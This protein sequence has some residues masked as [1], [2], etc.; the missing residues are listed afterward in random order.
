MK[1][2]LWVLCALLGV[3]TCKNV[4]GAP[5]LDDAAF[6]A[7][8]LELRGLPDEPRSTFD[9][10]DKREAKNV[11]NIVAIE[12][13]QLDLSKREAKN[14]VDLHMT[15]DEAKL[16]TRDGKN[17]VDLRLSPVFDEKRK[18]EG[19]NVVNLDLTLDDGLFKRSGCGMHMKM[20]DAEISDD[21]LEQIDNVNV[22]LGEKLYQVDTK[23]VDGDN[24]ALKLI[25]WTD[26]VASFMWNLTPLE[27]YLA[28][29]EAYLSSQTL[30][31][32]TKVSEPL[33]GDLASALTINEHLSLYSSYVR[34][35]SDVYT[36]CQGNY[37]DV[38]TQSEQPSQHLLFAPTNEALYSLKSKP[39]QFPTSVEG[40]SG[41]EADAVIESNVRSFVEAHTVEAEGALLGESGLVE[42]TT[43][44]GRTV[45]LKNDAGKG[46]WVRSSQTDWVLVQSVQVVENG[47][48]L[49]IPGAL[50]LP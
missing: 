16:M 41:S 23:E 14:V 19:K 26:S 39:W 22:R 29:A 40:L 9:L 27:S 11:V 32:S 1:L 10:L 4:V 28:K 7:L 5:I 17:V 2:A 37:E 25:P 42:L 35:L 43:L 31:G 30:T 8:E 13:P 33:K 45:F 48:L 44:N 34:T 38:R 20:K 21:Q 12:D 36:M 15:M 49:V 46:F 47:A 50:S 18:R 3:A 6:K 24:I